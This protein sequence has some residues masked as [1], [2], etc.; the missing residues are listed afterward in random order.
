MSPARART[1]KSAKSVKAP[2][3]R[4]F[5][6]HHLIPS[7]ELLT[8]AEGRQVLEELA[9][10]IERLPKILASDPGLLT[11]LAVRAAKEAAEPLSGRLIRVRRPS[12]TAGEAVAY[13]VVIA[14]LGD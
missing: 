4:E 2:S 1:R 12:P 13:R 8:E 7:H 14:N 9:T 11:A 5:Q 10:P 3:R 6:T